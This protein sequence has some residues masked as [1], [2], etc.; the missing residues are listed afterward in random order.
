MSNDSVDF[1]E[2]FPWNSNFETN[3]PKIDEQHKQLVHLL[4]RLAAH[5]AHRADSIELGKV[6]DELAAY[7]DYHF[8][9]EEEIWQPY[10][11]HDAWF[12]SHQHT[13]QSFITHVMDLKAGESE[14]PLDEVVEDILKFLTHWLA[15][16]ILDSDK[17]MAKTLQAMDSGFMLEEAKKQADQAM[18]G[19]MRLLIDTV[20][21]MY[22]SLSSRTLDLMR[23]RVERQKAEQALQ[24]AHDAL[25]Q[26]VEERT[27][28]L[29]KSQA[30]FYQAQK[31]E[32][33]GTLVGGIA[34]DF[35]NM[36][37]GITSN[38]YLIK[39][40]VR[41]LPPV[42][43]RLTDVETLSFRAANMIQQ[44]LTFARKG[45]V[46]MNPLPLTALMKETTKFLRVSMPE[47]I[48]FFE[49][50]SAE[51]LQ[52]MGNATQIH[53]LL[54][55]L[56]N[57]ARDAVEGVDSPSVRI[58]LQPF[59]VDETAVAFN[60]E[61]KPGH[62]AHLSVKDNGSGIPDVLQTHLFEPFFTTKEEGKGTGLGLSMVFGVVQAHE[63][64]VSLESEEGRGS[65]FHV[66]LPLQRNGS[67]SSTMVL[68]DDVV[69]GDRETILVVDDHDD[70]RSSTR[71]ILESMNYT[72]FEAVNGVE[73]VALFQAQQQSIDLL[74]MD[75]VMPQ[76]GGVEAVRQI[77]Q[78]R[79]NVKVIYMTGYDK[80]EVFKG[81]A[82]MNQHLVLSKPLKIETLSRVIQEQLAI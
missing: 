82:S 52:I 8:K 78:I 48:Q 24:E 31:M 34:H 64:V 20:L 42:M 39:K 3:I 56:V 76:L 57:N 61:L 14:K 77:Q 33:M 28:E 6:F 15:Y 54:M 32:A 40:Q 75:L 10:F 2:I 23:E 22:D 58:S 81:D 16:H 46:S 73:A 5:L 38:I 45:D 44:L 30:Q 27:A 59:A 12:V 68:D 17:R 79:P 36:L 80:G 51:P 35:N 62:Y 25:E 29:V 18:S 63:G 70:V 21:A 13:H 74:L 55:N 50:I 11:A 37:A 66:Y 65:T 53:Q 67:G 69:E 72:V 19:S 41:E 49:D 1:F 9:T 47:N 43:K 71:E 4:N 7:A 60:P 26:R